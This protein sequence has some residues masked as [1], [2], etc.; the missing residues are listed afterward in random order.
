[1]N[2][3]HPIIT[4]S[5]GFQVMSLSELRK[6]DA[7]G[8]TF[9]SHI[10]GAMVALTP[11]RAIEVQNLLGS[12]IVMQL[13]ECLALPATRDEIERA[14]RLS[15]V[16]AERCK[17]AFEG[18]DPGRALFGIVQGG[19]DVGLRNESARALTNIGFAGYAI[20]GLAVGEPQEVMLKMVEEVA[21]L[22]PADRP[23]YLMGVGRPDDLIEAVARGMDMFDCVMP[24]RD[25]R[26]GR[27]FTRFGAINLRN[28]RHAEDPRPLDEQSP[29]EPAR[30]YSRAYL[31]HLIRADEMLGAMLLSEINLAYYQELMAGIRGAIGAGA[32]AAFRAATRAAW[33][34]GDI[35]ALNP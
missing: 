8:V 9:R 11:E 17:R 20:G 5:G 4:D 13:D 25:G 18:S 32:F 6:L 27:A 21:P 24:T 35:P 19:D 23:R 16:W 28:A 22:L 3:P 10:D 14:M 1:M 12:D 30:I 2:W 15:L 34:R 26:H 7:N 31:H 29:C 33:E